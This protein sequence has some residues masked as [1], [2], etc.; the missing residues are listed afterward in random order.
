MNANFT[1]FFAASCLMACQWDAAA[2]TPIA[3][4]KL[5]ITVLED[6]AKACPGQ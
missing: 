6:G 5:W 4:D 2:V 1:G 3:S